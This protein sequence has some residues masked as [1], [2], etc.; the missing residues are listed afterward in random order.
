LKHVN[1]FFD[2]GYVELTNNGKKYRIDSDM[3][4]EIRS[5]VTKAKARKDLTI[6]D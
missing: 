2:N 6:L 4:E 5:L 1:N 3:Y